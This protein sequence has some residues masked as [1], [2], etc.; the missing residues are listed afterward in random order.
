MAVEPA[1]PLVT[2]TTKSPL[3]SVFGELSKETDSEIEVIDLATGLTQSFRK[4]DLQ[5]ISKNTSDNA[6]VERVGLSVFTTWR[7]LKVLPLASA[8]GKIAQ[9]DGSVIYVSLGSNVGLDVG[10]EISVY[11]GDKEIKDPDTGEVLGRLRRKIALLKAVEVEERLT[12]AT[13]VGDAEI[14]LELGDEVKPTIV[15]NSVAV[16]PFVTSAGAETEVTKRIAEELTTGLVKR[17]ISVVERRLLEKA[18]GELGLQQSSVFDSTKAQQ[19][20]KQIGAYAVVV[21][22]VAPKA[23]YVEAQ[24]RLVRVETGEI[25]AAASQI[26]RDDAVTSP[27]PPPANSPTPMKASPNDPI[28]VPPQGFTALFNGRNLANWRERSPGHWTVVDGVLLYD[29]R[30]GNLVTLKQFK[31]FELYVDWK[32]GATGDS[33]IYLRGKPQVQI[34]NDPKGSGGLYNNKVNPKNPSIRADNPIGEWNTF[35]ISMI[36][37]KVTVFLNDV[38]V[39][40]EVTFEN[41]PA[42]DGRL[43]IAGPIELQDAKSPLMFRNIFIR[44][45]DAPR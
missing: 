4:S 33:G 12:K 23:N 26:I 14:K 11:R 30:G 38:K 8:N 6:A 43:P 21:G 24:L 29:G 13:L 35:F 34:W 42:Y 31:N 37:N 41:W 3:R 18:L 32:I 27:N 10:K 7:I 45:V 28:N 44:Q 40:D 39:V 36:G 5:S 25:L 20:G 16:F 19:I 1:P 17:G 9:I 22:T 2:V 15:S